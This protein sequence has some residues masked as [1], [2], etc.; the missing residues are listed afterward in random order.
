MHHTYKQDYDKVIISDSILPETEIYILFYTKLD[1]ESYQKYGLGKSKYKVDNVWINDYD[2][3]NL[4]LVMPY[5]FK[6]LSGKIIY[7]SDGEE[8]FKII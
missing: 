1:P 7:Y 3:D 5:E 8:A 2:K 4:Y 6:N